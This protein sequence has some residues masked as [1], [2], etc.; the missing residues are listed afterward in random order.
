MPNSQKHSSHLTLSETVGSLGSSQKQKVMFTSS[1]L[2]NTFDE[3]LKRVSLTNQKG[4]SH[5]ANMTILKLYKHKGEF[6]LPLAQG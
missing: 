6:G 3:S 5:K 2:K 1:N 4:K